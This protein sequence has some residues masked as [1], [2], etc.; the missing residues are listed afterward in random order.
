MQGEYLG[1]LVG[2]IVSGVIAAAMVTLAEDLL[3]AGAVPA[4]Q[5]A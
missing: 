5:G 4:A 1:I 3:A 2:I